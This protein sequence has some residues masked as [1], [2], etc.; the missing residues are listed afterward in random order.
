[1]KNLKIITVIKEIM[2]FAATTISLIGFGFTFASHATYA[3]QTSFGQDA[4]ASIYADTNPAVVVIEVT[5][6]GSNSYGLQVLQNEVAYGLLVDNQGHIFTNN[7]VVDGASN[8]RVVLKTGN[9]AD[10]KVVGADPVND[11]ALI[12]IDS[13]FVSGITSLQPGDSSGAELG[14]MAIA[15]ERPF[16]LADSITMD[17]IGN[18]NK[19]LGGSRQNNDDDT[20]NR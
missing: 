15:L 4:G 18:L 19:K 5:R 13:S 17:V 1:M 9:T 3:A 10:A 8:V 6:P 2:V 16:T 12:S 7:H 20:A 11:I 14:Q